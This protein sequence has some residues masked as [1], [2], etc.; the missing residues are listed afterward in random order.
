MLVIRWRF[1]C[2]IID[3]ESGKVL[4]KKGRALGPKLWQTLVEH[5]AHLPVLTIDDFYVETEDGR[6]M[7]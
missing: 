3:P 2:D 5:G 1:P 7:I 6:R 4:A